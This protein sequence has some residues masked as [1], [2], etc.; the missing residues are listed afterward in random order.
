MRSSDPTDGRRR[1]IHPCVSPLIVW[2]AFVASAVI[3]SVSSGSPAWLILAIPS[4][5]FCYTFAAKIASGYPETSRD[6]AER[7]DRLLVEVG[8]LDAFKVVVQDQTSSPCMLF[9]RREPLVIGAIDFVQ[10][11]GD[12]LLR[13]VAAVMHAE[14]RDPQIV[15]SATKRRTIVILVFVATGIVL[16]AAAP[17]GNAV[18]GSVA[19]SGFVFWLVLVG[20][21]AWSRA[22]R[23][24]RRYGDVDIVAVS[25]A[26][27]AAVVAEALLAMSAWR[28]TYRAGRS[29]VA[30]IV[31]R[32][33]VP[34]P[35]DRHEA[36][37][38]QR[39]LSPADG[40]A[41]R[42]A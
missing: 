19:V 40:P 9:R 6:Q 22:G 3:V 18:F 28:A 36:D 17:A 12:E 15:K 23:A 37:R 4:V 11:A 29:R 8:G 5:L 30:R 34:L 13:G 41:Q 31:D 38:A 20:V 7:F 39:L 16:G 21:A 25:L 10:S 42:R 27:D 33:L 14:L 26:G 32:C 35:E 24:G 2:A 1:R